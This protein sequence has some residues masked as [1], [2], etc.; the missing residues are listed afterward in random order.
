MAELRPTRIP[1]ERHVTQAQRD[2][3]E[4]ADRVALVSRGGARAAVLGV[5]DGLVTNLSLI[6]GVA[7]ANAAPTSVRLAGLASLV[8]GALSMAA[9]EWVSVRSQVQLY[10]GALEEIRRLVARNPRLILRELASRLESA[11]LG[12]TTAQLAS[13]EL[14]LDEPRFM[15]FTARTVFGLDPDQLGSPLVA[16]GSSFALFAI[17]ALI[18]LLPW[19]WSSGPFASLLSVALTVVASAA[20]GG[21]VGR[22]SGRNAAR[23]ALVQV[24]VVACAAAV[25]FGIGKAF[26]SVVG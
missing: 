4:L 17:G 15:R 18:P 7:G 21:Y 1:I 16:A 14:P 20:V 10:S 3:D 13:T 19:L 5:S 25:T 23:G 2:T 11:G 6:L 12:R 26:G 8:A 22:T 24:T 9:G